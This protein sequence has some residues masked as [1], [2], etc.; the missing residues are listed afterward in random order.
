MYNVLAQYK[1]GNY[2]TTIYSDGTKVKETNED[3]FMPVFA[4]NI[5]IKITNKCDMNCPMC[6]ECSTIDGL[7]GNINEKFWDTL[8]PYQEV[9]LGGGNVLEYP[10]I[11]TLLYKLKQN[12][13]ITNITVN[14]K[15]FEDNLAKLIKWNCLKLIYGLGVSL[16]NVNNNFIN[17]LHLFDNTVVH[18]ING[19]V[20]QKQIEALSN[21]NIKLLILGY[22]YKGRGINNYNY[23]QQQI[24]TNQ[25]WLK[26][27]IKDLFNKFKVVSFDNLALKQLDIRNILNKDTWDKFYQGDDGTCTFYID[28]VNRKF[29]KSSTSEELYDLLDDVNNMFEVIQKE[30]KLCR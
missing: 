3:K 30:D 12:K 15:H 8:H 20:T 25:I 16:F 1:N 18:V 21:K 19:V 17:H 29:A 6:H 9:A 11:E 10:D 13:V 5:D 2:S 26:N 22:K 27:N 14:Q 7:H 23:N 24:K 4:E 28:A